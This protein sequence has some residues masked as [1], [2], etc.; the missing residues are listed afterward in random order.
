M[1][2]DCLNHCGDDP[3]LKDGRSEPCEQVRERQLQEA[4]T[5]KRIEARQVLH[6]FYNTTSIEDLVDA[7][8]HHIERLQAS[9]ARL[10]KPI[11]PNQKVRFA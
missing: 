5:A 1:K 4:I 11:R 9:L 6:K 10:E 8:T 7:Q 2:C 3:W